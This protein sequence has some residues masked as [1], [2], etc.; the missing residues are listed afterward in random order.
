MGLTCASLH[1]FSASKGL[2]AAALAGNLLAY[3]LTNNPEEAELELIAVAATP[4][5]SF[6][7]LTNPPAI[8]EASMDLGK[9]LSAGSACPALLTS[10]FDSDGFAFVVFE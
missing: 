10:V 2:Q 9:Q 7:D 8:T 6:F 4:W 5:V 1:V 3:E